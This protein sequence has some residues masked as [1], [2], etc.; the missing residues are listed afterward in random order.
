MTLDP[1]SRLLPDGS[2]IVDGPDECP[3]GHRLDY[4]N[5]LIGSTV[6]EIWYL[7]NTCRLCI[8]RLHDD[9]VEWVTQGVTGLA[10]PDSP[11]PG[12]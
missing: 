7:C 11:P 6:A 5:V 3:N 2:V 10:A 1:W 8:H 9:R 12:L 4:P